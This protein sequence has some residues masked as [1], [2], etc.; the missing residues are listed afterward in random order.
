MGALGMILQRESLPVFL[1]A[2]Q[3]FGVQQ[4]RELERQTKSK[5][6]IS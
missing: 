6:Y 3:F 5:F 4:D 1:I 2:S